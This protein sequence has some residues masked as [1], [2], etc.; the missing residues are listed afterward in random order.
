MPHAPWSATH[1]ALL[2]LCL[3]SA[4]VG[5]APLVSQNGI[6]IVTRCGSARHDA[7]IGRSP[8]DRSLILVIGPCSPEEFQ[9]VEWV[10]VAGGGRV[11]WAFERIGAGSATEFVAGAM[12][13][14]FRETTAL[15]E[16]PPRGRSAEL[17]VTYRHGVYVADGGLDLGAIGR[18]HRTGSLDGQTPQEFTARARRAAVCARTRPLAVRAAPRVLL[19]LCVVSSIA[20]TASRRRDTASYRRALLEHAYGQIE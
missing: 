20:L 14:S 18:I 1:L 3:I 15:Q 6:C 9:R 8:D 5:L 7:A 12:P 16:I 13:E 10:D 17:R 2:A 19:P 11:L 4:V